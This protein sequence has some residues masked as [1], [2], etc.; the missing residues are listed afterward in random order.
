M[1][2]AVEE[3]EKE[4]ATRKGRRQSAEATSRVGKRKKKKEYKK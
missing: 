1:K 3:K 4:N 2:Y